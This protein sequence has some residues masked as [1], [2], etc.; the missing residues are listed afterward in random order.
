MSPAPSEAQIEG[1]RVLIVT[2]RF[3]PSCSDGTQRLIAWAKSLQSR[4]AN[5]SILTA[6]WHS[7]W[8]P[9]LDFCEMPVHRL[10]FAP[11]N[12][13][14]AAR[15]SRSLADWVSKHGSSFDVIYCD[16]A[17]LEAQVILTQVPGLHRP[18][19]VIRFDPLELGEAATR[20]GSPVRGLWMLVG[21]PPL[22]S[23]RG[24]M[25]ISD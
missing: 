5:L 4:G 16:A 7:S 15:Y 19:V 1:P 10:E 23:P 13:M 22:L 20:D 9:R 17:D 14:R 3:W 21:E 6:R 18:P 24:P 2:R 8:S 11:T 12:P 25:H